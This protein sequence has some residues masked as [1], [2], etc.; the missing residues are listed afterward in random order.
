MISGCLFKVIPFS[1]I[2]VYVNIVSDKSI[3]FRR[4]I[5]NSNDKVAAMISNELMLFAMASLSKSNSF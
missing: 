5:A 3:D 2:S 1:F 4:L